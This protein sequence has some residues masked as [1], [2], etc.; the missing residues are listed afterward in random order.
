MKVKDL[1]VDG[2]K[3]SFN[4]YVE[5]YDSHILHYVF[6]N[7]LFRL[8]DHEQ[9]KKLRF[10]YLHNETSCLHLYA[11]RHPISNQVFYIVHDYT[12]NIQCVTPVYDH[13]K[14][15]LKFSYNKRR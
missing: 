2:W 12:R 15:C 11:L 1:E 13:V 14:D 4:G 7:H 8:N 10:I 6:I 5:N 9:F 3:I